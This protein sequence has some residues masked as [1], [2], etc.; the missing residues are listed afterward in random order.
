[1][2]TRVPQW[3]LATIATLVIPMSAAAA[4]AAGG[5]CETLQ[6]FVGSAAVGESHELKFHVIV[7]SNFKDRDSPAYG[8]RRCDYGSYEP[9]KPVCKFLMEYSSIE[10]PGYNAKS[11]IGCLSPKT[12]FAV[13]TWLYAIAYA[14]KLG[15]DARG[16][17]VDVV[18]SE[19][20]EVGG[21]MLSIKTTGY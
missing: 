14:V 21:V 15:T 17:R 3:I 16:S 19:D 2:N 9:A 12:K 18:L 11:V 13:G 5:L 4:A 1:M 8:A 20:K 10:S 6:D 7:G